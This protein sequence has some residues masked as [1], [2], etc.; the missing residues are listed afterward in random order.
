[1]AAFGKT[2]ITSAREELNYI[3]IVKTEYEDRPE[4]YQKFLLALQEFRL[5]QIDS[6]GVI[7]LL[8]N[9]LE[10]NKVLLMGFQVFLREG[11]IVWVT[12]ANSSPSGELVPVYQPEELFPLRSAGERGQLDVG[13][14][15]TLSQ[16]P[17]VRHE[18]RTAHPSHPSPLANVDPSFPELPTVPALTLPEVVYPNFSELPRAPAL[19]AEAFS[20]QNPP[21]STLATVRESG[22]QPLDNIMAAGVGR[23]ELNHEERQH[24][25]RLVQRSEPLSN[26]GVH[27]SIPN[28]NETSIEQSEIETHSVQHQ[29]TVGE[30][31]DG[32]LHQTEIAHTVDERGSPEQAIGE[33]RKRHLDLLARFFSDQVDRSRSATDEVAAATQSRSTGAKRP[34]GRLKQGDDA[35][36]P[37]L[38]PCET[39][40]DSATTHDLSEGRTRRNGW[41]A[42]NLETVEAEILQWHAAQRQQE[43]QHHPIRSF[44]LKFNECSLAAISMWAGNDDICNDQNNGVEQAKKKKKRIQYVVDPKFHLCFVCNL[45]GHYESECSEFPSLASADQ[46]DGNE[47]AGRDGFVLPVIRQPDVVEMCGEYLIEQRA[48]KELP[49][50]KIPYHRLAHDLLS[51]ETT[52]I[53]GSIITAMPCA[54]EADNKPL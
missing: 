48:T 7:N 24:G 10:K 16:H 14:A 35:S 11:S 20:L 23:T 33:S 5:N 12:D 50:N 19:M 32:A 30:T 45:W 28:Q 38:Q 46:M 18:V 1:M 9:L 6:S 2:A 41:A 52:E 54:N 4:I 49:S 8:Y 47:N 37:C 22:M 3:G 21:L 26:I 17:L 15:G 40:D 27:A 34:P 44:A 53:D 29:G 25:E 13:S 43:Q 39:S 51:G 36:K 31:T 42:R